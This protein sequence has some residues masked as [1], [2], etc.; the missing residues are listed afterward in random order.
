M[1]YYVAM[2]K[3]HMNTLDTNEIIAVNFFKIQQE[4]LNAEGKCFNNFI[5]FCISLN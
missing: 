4:G 1:F 5:L 3:P 2:L